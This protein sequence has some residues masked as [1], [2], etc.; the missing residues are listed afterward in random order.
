MT[1]WS[2]RS[3]SR[4][5]SHSWPVSFFEKSDGDH[6]RSHRQRRLCLVPDRGNVAMTISFFLTLGLL[7]RFDLSYLYPFQGLSV[8]LI[9]FAAAITLGKSYTRSCRSAR[10]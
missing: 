1:S 5:S 10:A 8:V 2:L 7:Q 3:F 9:A 4:R 6:G